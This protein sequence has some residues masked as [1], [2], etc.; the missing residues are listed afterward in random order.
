MSPRDEADSPPPV[1]VIRAGRKGQHARKFFEGSLVGLGLEDIGSVQGLSAHEV[2][3]RMAEALNALPKAQTYAAILFRFANELR[4]GDRVATPNA[5][6]G[7][8][9]FGLVAGEYFYAPDSPVPGCSHLRQM[10]W[11]AALRR[12]RLP[13]AVL[14]SIDTPMPLFF[15][16]NQVGL[17]DLP[18]WSA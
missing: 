7:T 5:E 2:R 3:D 14:R 4:I 15:P 8:V 13:R 10:T 17:R 1:W 6:D 9:L 16:G 12:E 18:V 11:L